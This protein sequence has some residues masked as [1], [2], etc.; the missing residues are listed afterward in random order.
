MVARTHA[1]ALFPFSK[2][3][4]DLYFHWNAGLGDAPAATVGGST[5]QVS[6]LSGLFAGSTIWQLS[7]TMNVLFEGVYESTEFVTVPGLRTAA[8]A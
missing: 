6:L 1:T 7:Q 5:A 2:R 8:I 4:G 3:F